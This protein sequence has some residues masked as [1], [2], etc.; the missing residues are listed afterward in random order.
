MVGLI[1]TGHGMFGTG[2]Y[3]AMIS[4]TG[5]KDE[6]YSLNFHNNKTVDMYEGKLQILVDDLV[7]RND[8][9]IILTDLS[10][11]PTFEVAME[12]ASQYSN[13]G[14][15]SS[16]NLNILLTMLATREVINDPYELLNMALIDHQN[17]IVFYNNLV[18]SLKEDSK[19]I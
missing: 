16:V 19:I 2:M 18:Y 14:V 6:I 11:G 17:I 10:E 15:V 1:V 4:M 13:V 8:S 3:E 9:V 12:V 5:K 7:T